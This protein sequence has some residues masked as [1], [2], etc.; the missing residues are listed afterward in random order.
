MNF[1]EPTKIYTAATNVEAQQVVNMLES[2]DIPAFADE[3]QS[4]PSLWMFGTIS[5]FHQ[6]NVWVDKPTAQQAAELIRHFEEDKRQHSNTQLAGSQVAAVCEE[7]KETSQFPATLN[8]TTQ[9]CPHCGAYMDVGEENLQ[10]E[11]GEAEFESQE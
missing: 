7:C 1:Q 11:F 6:P 2:N 5:Q 9:V 10:A 3:D 4:G 8:G